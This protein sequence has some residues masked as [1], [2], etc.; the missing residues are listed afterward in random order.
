MYG[1][2]PARQRVNERE[3]EHS[4]CAKEGRGGARGEESV[5]LRG[6]LAEADFRNAVEKF[7]ERGML[8]VAG[9]VNHP[10][11]V[12]RAKERGEIMPGVEI[13]RLVEIHRQ[14]PHRPRPE[15]GGEEDDEGDLIG[16]RLEEALHP[17]TR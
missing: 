2:H 7:H 14:L 16:A 15:E 17:V 9:V 6:V 13:D 11:P 10:A 1:Q 8:A 12:A 5:F 4:Q 3:D